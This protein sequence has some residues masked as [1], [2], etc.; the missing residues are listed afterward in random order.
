MDKFQRKNTRNL[1]I[2]HSEH[3]LL[4]EADFDQMHLRFFHLSEDKQIL[5]QHLS[6][7]VKY[8]VGRGIST[9]MF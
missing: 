5:K 3:F 8:R 4:I 7:A 2:K 6:G 1:E 9:G